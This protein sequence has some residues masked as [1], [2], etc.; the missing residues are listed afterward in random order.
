MLGVSTARV[1]LRRREAG[2]AAGAL[3]RLQSFLLELRKLRYVGILPADAHFGHFLR[4]REPL[5]LH[6]DELLD[7]F[8]R[9]HA[10]SV[11]IHVDFVAELARSV[12]LRR[13]INLGIRL[14]VEY[15]LGLCDVLVV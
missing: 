2:A 4:H 14:L 12:E 7:G 1:F 6:V 11:L 15:F 3:R 10:Q 9:E 13:R 5:L 8:L